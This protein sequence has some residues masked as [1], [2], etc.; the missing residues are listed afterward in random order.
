MDI[1]KENLVKES[2][3]TRII[4]KSAKWIRKH[5]QKG[6]WKKNKKFIKNDGMIFIN[7]NKIINGKKLERK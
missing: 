7:L 4:N 6:K 1:S 2:T 5:I 3:C